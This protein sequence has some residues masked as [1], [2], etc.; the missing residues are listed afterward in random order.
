M[1]SRLIQAA[2]AQ[3]SHRDA[4]PLRHDVLRSQTHSHSTLVLTAYLSL[5]VPL[6]HHFWGAFSATIPTTPGQA[7]AA[8]DAG[9]VPAGA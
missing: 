1:G 9:D 3:E 5:I 7:P 8:C 2:A 4:E 6:P